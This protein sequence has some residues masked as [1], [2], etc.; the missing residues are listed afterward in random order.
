MSRAFADA[1]GL[2]GTGGA[3]TSQV[4]PAAASGSPAPQAPP[5][6]YMSMDTTPAPGKRLLQDAI[7]FIYFAYA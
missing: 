2:S 7:R 4:A 1:L 5:F 3:S 6:A